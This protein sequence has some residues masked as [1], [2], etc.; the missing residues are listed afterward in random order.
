MSHVPYFSIKVDGYGATDKRCNTKMKASEICIYE[1]T[2]K[3]QTHAAY[4]KENVSTIMNQK[5]QCSNA[6]EVAHP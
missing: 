2:D 4:L 5:H 6:M 1:F 3:C